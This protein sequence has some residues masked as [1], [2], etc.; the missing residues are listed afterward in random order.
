MNKTRKLL[1]MSPVRPVTYVPGCSGP[2]RS[3]GRV[4]GDARRTLERGPEE[5]FQEVDL[6]GDYHRGQP[7]QAAWL[8]EPEKL[9]A[10]WK[11]PGAE[12]ERGKRDAA[13]VGPEGAGDRGDRHRHRRRAVPPALRARLPGA[14]S[15]AST[16]RTRRRIGIRDNRYEADCP[17][18]RRRSAASAR[19]HGD[20]ARFTRAHT[21]HRLKLTMPGPMTIVDTL[22]DE[23]LQG[24]R[25]AGAWS[26]PAAQPGGA[27]AGGDRRRRDPVRRARLQRVPGGSG[28][29]GDRRPAPRHRGPDVQDR[30][31]H[32]LRLRHPG[33]HRLEEHPGLGMAAV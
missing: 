26:S 21:Q 13:L 24:P 1:P 33:Q 20:E 30:R 17:T 25:A 31:A 18:W 5:K 15:R 9:W 6:A 22:A 16:S 10:P 8:A 4:R 14:A 23:L 7:A 2:A 19:V 32:L 12:L 29:V 3:A 27:G 28:G 11:L